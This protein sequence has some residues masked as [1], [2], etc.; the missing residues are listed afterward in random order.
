MSLNLHAIY[1]T[2]EIGNKAFLPT[3]SLTNT[4]T[5]IQRP[6]QPSLPRDLL[7]SFDTERIRLISFQM[8]EE[9]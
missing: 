9:A 4:L 6:K 5:P 2:N 8:D 1:A 7:E 3:L